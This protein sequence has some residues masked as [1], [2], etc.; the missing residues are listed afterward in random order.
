[1]ITNVV[2]CTD[3]QC[4]IDLKALTLSAYNIIYNPKHFSGAMWRNKKIG[5]L[6]MV[7]S[8]SKLMVNG[9]AKSVKECKRRV[10]KYTRLLQRYGWHVHLSTIRICTIS[11]FF[12][13]DF[14]PNLS[15]VK[16]YFNGTYE[17]EIFPALMFDNKGVHFTV[18][19][20]GAVLMTGL[21]RE[22]QVKEICMPTLLEI[23]LL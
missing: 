9:K 17:P 8:N 3:L 1:M 5:G 23:S 12:K 11:A 7:F 13:L 18:F 15:E 19:C 6:C 20:S 21:K 22:S 2:A 10:R 14:S 4:K 16:K